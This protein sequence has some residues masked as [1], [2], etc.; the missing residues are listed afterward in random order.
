MLKRKEFILGAAVG[1]TFAAA[2]TAGGIIDWPAAGAQEQRAEMRGGLVPAST[3]GAVLFQPPPGAPNSF[4]DIIDQVSPAVVQIDVTTRVPRPTMRGFPNIPGL[5]FPFSVPQQPE[6]EDG[7]APMMEGAGSGSG[8][9]ISADGFIVT[10]N[11]VVANASEIIVR[12]SD[13]RELT[14]RIVGRD[15]LTDL[16]VLKVDG[17]NF[18]FVQFETQAQPRVGDWVVAL[19]NPFGLGGSATAGI[20]SARGRDIGDQYVDFIQ[21]D[22]PINRGNSGG[23]TFDIYG[24]VIGVN[25]AIFSPTGVSVGIGFAIPADVAQ[26]V[27]QQLMQGGSIERGYLGVQIGTL[28]PDMREALGL[29]EAVTGAYVNDVTPGGPAAAAGLRAEDVV[30]EMN[31]EAVR[32]NTDLTRRVGQARAGDTLRLTILREGRRIQVN[33]RAGARPP[34]DQLNNPAPGEQN[35]NTERPAAAGVVV[36]GLRVAPMSAAL[37]QQYGIDP[38]INGLVILGAEA[39]SRAARMGFEPGMVIQSADRRAVTTVDELRAAVQ[40]LRQAGRPSILLFVRT[41]QGNTP[42]VLPL[43]GDEE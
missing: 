10:N 12:L 17:G 25:T 19:G 3:A 11:H 27:T 20:V 22:A 13:D 15:E 23:P 42:V 7:E 40:R 18:P 39:G 30:T 4:A 14:A 38:Q 36:E 33:V 28:T 16:A 8:F 6:S 1:L 29:D 34:E 24:R 41:R 9:F 37:R 21:I 5:P 43:E 2:A 26:R 31:G 35:G 32:N